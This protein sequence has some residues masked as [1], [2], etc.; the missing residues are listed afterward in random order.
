MHCKFDSSENNMK[1][2]LMTILKKTVKIS[3]FLKNHFEVIF[4]KTNIFEIYMNPRKVRYLN[5]NYTRNV[6]GSHVPLFQ[7][8]KRSVEL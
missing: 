5:K 4:L 7:I 3:S 2:A 8:F 1:I 6:G